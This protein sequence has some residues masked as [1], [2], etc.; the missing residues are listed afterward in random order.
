MK[1]YLTTFF[2]GRGTNHQ[3]IVKGIQLAINNVQPVGIFTGDNLFAF[4]RNLGFLDDNEFMNAFNKN[5]ETEMER[6][7]IW[8]S[9]V[10]CW[11]ARTASR[12]SGD[13]VECGCYKGTSAKI[14]CD[15]LGFSK[16]DK[17]FYM[18]DLFEHSADMDH[19]AMPEHSIDLYDKVKYRFSGIRNAKIIKG[20]LPKI[21]EEISPKIISFL[22]I[23]LNGP[24]AE[25]GALEILFDKVVPGGMIILDDYGWLD[26]RAQKEA[27]D[28]FFAARGYRILELPTGQGLVI[29]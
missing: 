24:S 20:E 6:A 8:R 13:F 27:E 7:I 10:L 3:E 9:H 15:Y 18:Y 25:I 22:H 29:K 19:H 4:G 21:L 14:I 11:A 26:Y 23:D 12:L 1:N 17:S 5:I 16:I 28:P 2:W